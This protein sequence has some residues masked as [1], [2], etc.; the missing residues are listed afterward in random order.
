MCEKNRVA[1]AA[2]LLSLLESLL[3]WSNTTALA[4]NASDSIHTTY[5]NGV[6]TISVFENV[7]EGALLQQLSDCN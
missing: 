7:E 4:Q 5:S 2:F 1:I 3:W 6:T